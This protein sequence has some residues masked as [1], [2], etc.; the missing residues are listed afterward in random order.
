MEVSHEALIR[1][2]PRLRDWIDA[3]GQDLA[4]TGGSPRPRASGCAWSTT[5]AP[6]TAAPGSTE[7]AALREQIPEAL[8]DA[9]HAFLDASAAREG[10]ARRQELEDARELAA[11]Q[12]RA[13]RGLVAVAA[14]LFAGVVAA[15]T[16]ALVAL[17]ARND[18]RHQRDRALSPQLASAAVDALA[19]NPE[20]ALL[21][22]REAASRARTAQADDALRAALASPLESVLAG[23]TAQIEIMEFSADG[24]FLA[25]AVGEDDVRV[26]DLDRARELAKIDP[27][28]G[29]LHALALAPGGK[30]LLIAGARGVVLQDVA[31]GTSRGRLDAPAIVASECA[32][33][34][35]GKRA[36]CVAAEEAR[37]WD[38]AERKLLAAPSVAPRAAARSVEAGSALSADGSIVALSTRTGAIR[39]FSVD[40]GSSTRVLPGRGRPLT[41]LQLDA[42]GSRVLDR[43]SDGW[44]S[45]RDTARGK[46]LFRRRLAPA[47][48]LILHPSGRTL[49]TRAPAA[50]DALTEPN[51][52]VFDLDENTSAMLRTDQ[53]GAVDFEPG[54]FAANGRSAVAALEQGAVVLDLA[55]GR[56]LRYL[57]LRGRTFARAV[58]VPHGGRILTTDETGA[59]ITLWQPG[60]T[61]LG[62]AGKGFIGSVFSPDGDLIAGADGATLRFW[63]LATGQT[64]GHGAAIST[65]E[66]PAEAG[67]SL[68]MAFSRDGRRL[69]GEPRSALDP[70]TSIRG[71][72]GY[73]SRL[74]PRRRPAGVVRDR[75]V[76]HAQRAGDRRGGS[77]ARVGR[78]RC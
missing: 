27:R 67:R 44:I 15:T 68:V 49:V 24:R 10:D 13:K 28:L 3:A 45:V 42:T 8:N 38:V 57:R 11:A 60:V 26:W 75:L 30:L 37:I 77:R 20:L 25:T 78:R 2:W 55:N 39:L 14:V 69:R 34:P 32:F 51:H 18:A 7:A 5:T 43:S 41:S 54:S 50:V 6:C 71:R 63:D 1:G 66:P 12:R 21:L 59:T 53:F 62:R 65:R 48:R 74:I 64:R 76:R 46:T 22:A 73:R 4:C 36:A 40:G 56:K 72:P 23:H 70:S 31:S 16:L 33:T 58:Y 17:G 47:T 19:T 35:S 61:P 29:S 52:R 9:E